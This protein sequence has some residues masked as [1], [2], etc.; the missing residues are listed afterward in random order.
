MPEMFG[1]STSAVAQFTTARLTASVVDSA[2]SPVAGATVQIEQLG[3]G[4][5]T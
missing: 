3:T 5:R 1:V 2:C 4:F